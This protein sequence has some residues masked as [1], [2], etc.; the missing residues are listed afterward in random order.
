MRFADPFFHHTVERWAGGNPAPLVRTDLASLK[1]LDDAPSL[2]PCALIFHVSRCGS[3]LLSRLLGSVPGV[4]VVSEPAPVNALLLA[5]PAALAPLA[6][7]EALRLLVRAL[8]R[9]RFGDERHYVL[10][11][12]SWNVTRLNLFRRAFPRAALI[13]LQRA[14]HEVAA[15]LVADPPGWAAQQDLAAAGRAIFGLG[16]APAS[17]DEFCVRAVETVLKA[18]GAVPDWDLVVDHADLPAA[19]WSQVAPRLGLAL[20]AEDIARMAEAARFDAKEPTPLLFA[21]ERRRRPLP[22][23]I[24]VLL[25]PDAEPIYAALAGRDLPHPA[26][27]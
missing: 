16:T 27:L 18:A 10:K 17:R 6:Q 23:P 3:T 5:D 11:L 26:R 25:A 12:S 22:E 8:G 9:Q 1:A 20:A 19:A 4:L 15:S 21:G 24:R 2:D 7:A 14:P 13:W